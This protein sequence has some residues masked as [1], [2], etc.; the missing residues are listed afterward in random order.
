M[1]ASQESIPESERSETEMMRSELALLGSRNPGVDP[2]S[3][4]EEALQWWRKNEKVYPNLSIVFKTIACIP[5]TQ[6]ECERI[7]SVAGILTR[8]RRS[9]LGSESLC[10]ISY[11]H[12]NM[13]FEILEELGLLPNEDSHIHRSE[14]IDE[15]A[16]I[17]L[18]ES[19]FPELIEG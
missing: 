18:V 1:F 19:S 3:S 8:G 13:T 5:P 14:S 17:N 6:V 10:D 15:G 16:L 12:H 4:T 7:F 2:H 9:R 11:L